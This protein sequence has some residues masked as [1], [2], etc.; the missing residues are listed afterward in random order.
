MRQPL[1][2][3]DHVLVKNTANETKSKFG[4]QAGI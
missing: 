3:D 2:P 4:A 1:L